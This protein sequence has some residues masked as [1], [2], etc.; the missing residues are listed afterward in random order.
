[1]CFSLVFTLCVITLVWRLTH[2]RY[3]L[4][5]VSFA[6]CERSDGLKYFDAL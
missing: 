6:L 4:I 2:L 3:C 5:R 1:M